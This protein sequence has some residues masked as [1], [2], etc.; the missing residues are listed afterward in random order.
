[1]ITRIPLLFE[2][3][4]HT[5]GDDELALTEVQIL[6]NSHVVYRWTLNEGEAC[7]VLHRGHLERVVAAKI[8]SMLHPEGS[9]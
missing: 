8:F 2:A 3:I 7:R 6:M 5:R 1:M 9:K 4:T